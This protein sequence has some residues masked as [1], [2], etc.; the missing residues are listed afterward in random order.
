MILLNLSGKPLLKTVPQ[1]CKSR[2]LALPIF[3]L[4]FTDSKLFP[5]S[6]EPRAYSFSGLHTTSVSLTYRSGHGS[7]FAAVPAPRPSR[8]ACPPAGRRAAWA[9]KHHGQGLLQTE[10][11]CGCHGTQLPMGSGSH[12]QTRAGFHGT[13]LQIHRFCSA[14]FLTLSGF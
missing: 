13:D 6:N 7:P 12:N 11:R 4:L 1:D 10:T 14:P 2:L 5:K 8:A 9:V 3:L